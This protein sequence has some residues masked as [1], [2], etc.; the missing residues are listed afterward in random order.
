MQVNPAD[1]NGASG[2]YTT[3]PW[4]QA[5]DGDPSTHWLLN[6]IGWQTGAG[7]FAVPD[8][9]HLVELQQMQD[10]ASIS[11]LRAFQ[12]DRI[13]PELAIE[14]AGNQVGSTWTT[15]VVVTFNATDALSGV[16]TMQWRHASGPWTHWE[17]EPLVLAE[18]NH[19]LHFAAT[20]DAGLR[21]N[22]GPVHVAVDLSPPRMPSVIWSQSAHGVSVSW[23]Q[24]PWDAV[25]GLRNLSIEWRGAGTGGSVPVN[26]T[27][28]G[29]EPT[30]VAGAAGHVRLRAH[31]HAGWSAVTPWA[32]IGQHQPVVE[33]APVAVHGTWTFTWPGN[34]ALPYWVD[35]DGRRLGES[36]AGAGISFDTTA[37][38]DGRHAVRF[39]GVGDDGSSHMYEINMTV[40]N[41]PWPTALRLAPLLASGVLLAGAALLVAARVE[42]VAER[43]RF[44]MGLAGVS[45]LLLT[46][47]PTQQT[48]GV[49][50]ASGGL[51]LAGVALATEAA[52]VWK[53]RRT[54]SDS[55][56]SVE[57]D[58]ERPW[59]D[60]S[61]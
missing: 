39:T 4:V 43:K 1:P 58:F 60:G 31:D 28:A 49:W 16:A 11:H 19:A 57:L 34:E 17:H 15:P 8:G 12:V 56:G 50:L 35:V 52:L 26:W 51:I 22:E 18:G 27:N 29:T 6:G 45:L 5:V 7:P 25:S 30:S 42:A 46:V 10:G 59:Q 21:S 24:P 32:P 2:W 33:M 55:S 40:A 38:A 36:A 14:L 44:M 3:T 9:R 47:A 41:G 54:A 37:L 61:R 13:A 23:L 53:S 20:D 48:E